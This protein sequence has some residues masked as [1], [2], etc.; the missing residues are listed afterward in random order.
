MAPVSAVSGEVA[1]EGCGTTALPFEEVDLGEGGLGLK[2][3]RLKALKATGKIGDA[4]FDWAL[5]R[6]LRVRAFGC[7]GDH[8]L[9]KADTHLEGWT[10]NVCCKAL[11]VGTTVFSC[12]E[13]DW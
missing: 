12:R 3:V 1:A 5:K 4:H 7:S 9:V 6:L 13:C 11:P 8:E 10:C 2:L